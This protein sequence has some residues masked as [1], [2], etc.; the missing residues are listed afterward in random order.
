MVPPVGRQL[1]DIRHEGLQQSGQRTGE[2]MTKKRDVIPN[3][4]HGA[5]NVD[6]G[7]E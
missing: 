6:K 2:H 4:W 7:L 5:L 1:V 3:G